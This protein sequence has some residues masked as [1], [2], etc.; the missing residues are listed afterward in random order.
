[1]KLDYTSLPRVEDRASYLY[2]E[3]A[4]IE[5]DDSSIVALMKSGR[6]PIPVK[7]ISVL[8]L[9]SGTL[10]THAAIQTMSLNGL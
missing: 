7:S 6:I 8:L 2:V 10:V 3:H 9:G 4:I 1:M 5:Q